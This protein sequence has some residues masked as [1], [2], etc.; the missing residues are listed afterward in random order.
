MKKLIW[1]SIA[2]GV[3]LLLS[4]ASIPIT[5]AQGRVVPVPT[6]LMMAQGMMGGGMMGGGMGQG[7]NGQSPRGETAANP[8]AENLV[9]YVRSNGLACFSCHSVGTRRIGPAF[10]DVAR[11]YAGQAN[12][13]GELAGSIANGVAGKWAGYPAMPSG[14]ASPTQASKLATLILALERHT[15]H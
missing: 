4:V 1:G 8:A 10:D 11:R 3:T 9:A 6:R 7:M 14:L 5:A 2:S 15:S 13:Q 12:G